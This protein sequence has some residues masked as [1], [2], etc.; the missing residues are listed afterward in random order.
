MTGGAGGGG[1][2]NLSLEVVVSLA[3]VLWKK[4]HRKEKWNRTFPVEL[5]LLFAK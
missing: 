1:G 2:F 5:G 3:K 4:R